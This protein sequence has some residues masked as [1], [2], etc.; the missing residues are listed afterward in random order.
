MHSLN[1]ILASL[2]AARTAA[3]ELRDPMLANLVLLGET[4][5]PTGQEQARVALLLERFAEAGL[6]GGGTDEQGNGSAVLPGL[7]NRRTI[8]L[9]AP[10]DTAGP[11]DMD[12]SLEIEP[13]RVVGPFVADN[14]LALAAL[15]TLPL[16]LE[17]LKIRLRSRVV[18]LAAVRCMGRGNLEGLKFFLA[19][20]PLPV[21]V[22]LCLEGVQLGRMNY[23]CLGMLRGEIVCRLPESY[24]WAQYGATGTIIPMTDVITRLNGIPLPRRPLSSLVLGA[25]RGGFSYNTIAPSTKLQFEV[26]SESADI[27]RDVRARIEAIAQDVA[28]QAGVRVAVEFLAARDPG[29]LS[30]ADPLVAGARSI[31]G[32]LGLQ[33]MAYL[34]TSAMSAFVDRGIPALTLGVTRGER[35]GTAE[36]F[37]EAAD[38]GGMAIGLAQLAGMLQLMDLEAADESR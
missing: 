12:Q 36:E 38:I 21:Q 22:G 17:R 34:T 16:L 13:G 15:A 32:A 3:E 35:R 37:D 27:L 8:L 5:A 20:G 31:L 19:H 25:I 26:R 14:S 7:D 1:E 10:A 2:P 11:A 33:P 30:A 18:F 28:A 29:G 24:N 4:P 9:T 23:A 6:E